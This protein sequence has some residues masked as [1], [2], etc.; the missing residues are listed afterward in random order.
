MSTVTKNEATE[1]LLN[2]VCGLPYSVP[3][4]GG[5]HDTPRNE[6]A[7]YARAYATEMTGWNPEDYYKHLETVGATPE[8]PDFADLVEQ[9]PLYGVWYDNYNEGLI[10]LVQAVLDRLQPHIQPYTLQ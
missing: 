8:G 9:H 10:Q 2:L 4:Y 7:E 6:M 5:T 3:L 1:A